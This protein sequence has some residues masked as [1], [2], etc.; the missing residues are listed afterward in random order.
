[1]F[2]GLDHL[3]HNNRNFEVQEMGQK[4]TGRNKRATGTNENLNN[5]LA[6]RFVLLLI[7][8]LRS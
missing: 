7:R 5:N 3:D 1:M 2:K 6:E 8:W 4:P